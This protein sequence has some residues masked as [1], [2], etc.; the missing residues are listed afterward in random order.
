MH[1]KLEVT[2]PEP[3][4]HLKSSW[5]KCHYDQ[6]YTSLD[7]L[8]IS[9]RILW[10]IKNALY[11]LQIPALVPEIF[12]FEK[13]AEYANEMTDD[14]IHSTQYYIK[15]INRAIF[16]N[17]QRRSLKLGRLIFL[18]KTPW[19]LTLFQSPSTWFQY[20]SDLCKWL[21][22]AT[23]SSWH[24]CM[25]VWS[26]IWGTICKYENGMPKV[27]RNALNIGEVWNPVCCHGNKTV[28]LKLWSTFSR[29]LLQR[30]KH[31]DSNWLRYIFFIVFDQIWLS[32]WRHHLANLAYFK[33]LNISRTKRD[34]WK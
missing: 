15:C 7:F 31:S 19:E 11:R 16:A 3:L 5:T 21:N 13:C 25:L 8:G 4:S 1:I 17:L 6:I 26:C 34:T 32:V 23:N 27:A 20:V 33:S 9:H 12:K 22:K 30:I 24:I 28:T 10:K 18:Q 29:I 14:V 2:L